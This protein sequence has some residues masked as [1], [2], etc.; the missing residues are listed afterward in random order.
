MTDTPRRT[1]DLIDEAETLDDG[2]LDDVLE[3]GDGGPPQPP[4]EDGGDDDGGS[5]FPPID[6]E[7]VRACALLDQNDTDNGRRLLN[8]FRDEWL[9]VREIGPHAWNGRHWDPEGGPESLERLAQEVA[10]RI[11][12]EG[13]EIQPGKRDREA[14][15]VADPLL[16]RAADELSEDDKSVLK[17][18][19][20][21]RARLGKRRADR[22]KFAVSCGN[23]ART[24]AMI[25]QAMPHRTVPPAALDADPMMFNLENGTLVFSR[26][27]T[28]EP[29]PECPDP[30]VVR[31]RRKVRVAMRLVPHDR[32]HLIAKIAP[33]AFDR[34]ARCRRFMRFLR[35]F[36]PDRRQRKFLQEAVG[37][38][39]IG[40]ATTQVLIFLYG[41]G[42]NGKSAFMET[43]AE[44]LGAYAGRLK[45]ESISGLTE[46]RGDQATPDFARLAG[47]R[48]VAIAE[49]PRG[50]P[51][52]EGLVKT[53]T[54]G[55]PMPVRHLNKG[56]FDLLPE[57][58]PFM[59][60]NDLPEVGGLD[61]GIW[62]RL[63]F[64][65]WP[66]TL[67]EGEQRPLHDVVNEFLEEAPGILNWA[68][69][70]ALRFLRDGLRDPPTVAALTAAHR[71]DLDPVGAF[72][73]ACVKKRPG[74]Q[75]QARTMYEAF[76]SFCGANAIRAWK[77]TAFGKAMKKKGFVRDDKRI[78][79]WLD[80]DLH[81]V[82]ARPEPV[83]AKPRSPL[84]GSDDD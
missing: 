24:L 16:G 29:D 41:D 43:I 77:E 36:Q 73:A 39:L 62:R 28:H 15:E 13:P 31:T 35:R 67:D 61:H 18:G 34:R 59:S 52:R 9:N 1:A 47:K 79:L 11:K 56:F 72:L 44:L 7:T 65:H 49:L 48:F 12:L 27:V 70:G 8:H 64:V 20:Q 55:E 46:G 17:Q 2:S 14:M 75:V 58:I 32:M 63:K 66:V 33:V 6:P 26:H 69:E 37:R 68:I 57:F 21:A 84:D 25:A 78:R 10:R 80:V 45:P 60:G 71:S 23:R 53:M 76:V 81:D 3:G 40:G 74:S 4:G 82:P 22:H 19:L 54:G 51:L 83:T 38:A 5:R 30:D 42:A 50:A